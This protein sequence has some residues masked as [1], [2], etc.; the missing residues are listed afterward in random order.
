MGCRCAISIPMVLCLC[1]HMCNMACVLSKT[2]LDQPWFSVQPAP[3]AD[4]LTSWCCQ[5]CGLCQEAREIKIRGG[6]LLLA[7]LH[8]IVDLSRHAGYL[9]QAR[10]MCLKSMVAVHCILSLVTTIAAI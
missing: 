10:E 6:K 4:C 7:T 8:A 2:I 9:R 5:P 1:P 3:C